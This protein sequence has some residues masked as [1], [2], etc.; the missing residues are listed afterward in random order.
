MGLWDRLSGKSARPSEGLHPIVQRVP[1]PVAAAP[2]PS[3]ARPVAR[4]AEKRPAALAERPA[5]P[6]AAP[7]AGTRDVNE[8][9]GHFRRGL[10]RQAGG[11]HA[12]AV[13]EFTR[14]IEL[15]PKCAEAYASRGISREFLGDVAGAKTDYA[16]S[17]GLE[18][19]TEISKVATRTL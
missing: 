9:L 19:R 2:R 4:P 18:V 5:P 8:S 12:A 15:D 1:M 13:E 3:L 7:A 11:D 16:T 17:I 10:M 6:P 14:A